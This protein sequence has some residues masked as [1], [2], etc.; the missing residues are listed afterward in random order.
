MDSGVTVEW[1]LRPQVCQAI[2]HRMDRPHID[3]FASRHN[4]QLPTY[5]LWDADPL[6]LGRDTLTHDWSV[7]LAYAFPP[8]ALILNVYLKLSRTLNWPRQM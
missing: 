6:S 2:F 4:H 7:T 1:R 8:I 3:M 5:Y